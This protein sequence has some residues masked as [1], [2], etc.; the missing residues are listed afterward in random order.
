VP[1]GLHER[2]ELEQAKRELETQV[3]QKE[4]LLKE[5][6][7][8]V[9]NSLQIVSSIL[10]LQVIQSLPA[11]DAMRSAASR[12]MAVAAVHERL[13]TG[14]DVRVVALDAFLGH[15]CEEIGRALGCADGIETDIAPVDAFGVTVGIGE[16]ACVWL[17]Y[18]RRGL[19][20][21]DNE[22]RRAF[23]DGLAAGLRYAR[24]Q[25]TRHPGDRA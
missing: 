23:A 3:E 8:R 1:A 16:A 21:P 15:L 24:L 13:Y 2:R 10:E 7:H 17:A 19:T 20:A 11:A 5:V 4:L 9:K 14:G 25:A 18:R 22:V 6:N 12:V